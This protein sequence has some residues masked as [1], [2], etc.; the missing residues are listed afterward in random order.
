MLRTF[1]VR[2]SWMLLATVPFAAHADTLEKSDT[3]AETATITVSKEDC[4]HIQKYVAQQDVTY[5]PGVDVN[6][7]P[8]APADLQDNRLVLPENIVIDLNLP[9]SDLLTN[10]PAG[11]ENAEAYI[12]TL[13]YNLLSGRLTFN[14]Q[15]LADPAIHAI[16]EEC[17]KQYSKP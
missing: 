11:L 16:A 15:E 2:L 13:K 9:L 1:F 5:K 3:P 12:G 8:V 6:G 14:G 7:N 17:R 10:P 4:S